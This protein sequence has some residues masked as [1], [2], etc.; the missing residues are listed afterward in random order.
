[1]RFNGVY[2]RCQCQEDAAAMK[3]LQETERGEK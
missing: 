2:M 3:V 1:M